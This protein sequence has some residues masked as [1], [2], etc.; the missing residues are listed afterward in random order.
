MTVVATVP[1]RLDYG[2]TSVHASGL[3]ALQA[4][5]MLVVALPPVHGGNGAAQYLGALL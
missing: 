1:V 4:L 2:L 3:H 5:E